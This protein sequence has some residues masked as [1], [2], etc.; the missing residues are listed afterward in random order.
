MTRCTTYIH[1]F[2]HLY[3]VRMHIL[4]KCFFV[5]LFAG[6]FDCLNFSLELCV[7]VCVCVCACARVRACVHACMRACVSTSLSLLFSPQY[8]SFWLS[9][10]TL[11]ADEYLVYYKHYHNIT[12]SCTKNGIKHDPPH[13][14]PPKKE[15]KCI[16]FVVCSWIN[17]CFC[18]ATGATPKFCACFCCYPVSLK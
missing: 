14:H 10:W 3:I 12:V 8:C 4:C 16:S 1:A 6:P 13:P 5:D 18:W 9:L 15:A 2:R 7:C 11:F 17:F